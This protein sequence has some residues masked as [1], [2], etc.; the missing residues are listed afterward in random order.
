MENNNRQGCRKPTYD[1]ITTHEKWDEVYA[2][3]KNE[4]YSTGSEEEVD[5]IYD[6]CMRRITK[7]IETDRQG[8][9]RVDDV[10]APDCVV[11]LA[12]IDDEDEPIMAYLSHEVGKWYGVH[13]SSKYIETP[14]HWMPLPNKPEPI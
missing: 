9:T 1:E 11:V 2:E 8:W 7:I 5:K 14:S 3:L 12:C 4:G 10:L 13:T 6:E